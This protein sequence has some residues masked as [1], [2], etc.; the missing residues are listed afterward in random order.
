MV[1]RSTVGSSAE[2]PSAPSDRLLAG[3]KCRNDYRAKPLASDE[4]RKEAEKIKRL[5]RKVA[6]P[7]QILAIDELRLRRME[8]QSCRS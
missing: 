3:R 4:R 2:L 1:Q 5:D 6:T 8:N 7:V